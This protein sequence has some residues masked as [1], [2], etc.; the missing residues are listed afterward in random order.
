[1][2]NRLSIISRT[3]RYTSISANVVLDSYYK[4]LIEVSKKQY[5]KLSHDRVHA[6]RRA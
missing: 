3:T 1:V 5:Y 4:I 2:T 6:V